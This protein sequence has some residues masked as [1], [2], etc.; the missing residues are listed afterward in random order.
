MYKSKLNLMHGV[1]T[2]IQEM[3][4]DKRMYENDLLVNLLF[5]SF[6]KHSFENQ[7]RSGSLGI[8]Y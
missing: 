5:Y 2:N 6:A 4:G 8:V 7:V 3:Y 1:K